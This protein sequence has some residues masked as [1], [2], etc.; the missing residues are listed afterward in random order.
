M[1]DSD[2]KSKLITLPKEKL[3]D[4]LV[5]IYQAGVDS[6]CVQIDLLADSSNIDNLIK[7]IEATLAQWK[8]RRAFI[9]YSQSFHYAR[10]IMVV[11]QKIEHE[12]IPVDPAKALKLIKK[13]LKSEAKLIEQTDDSGG[14]IGHE[15]AKFPLL[16]LKAASMVKKRS[17]KILDEVLAIAMDNDYGI[18]DGFLE[19]ADILLGPDDLRRLLQ[20]VITMAGT[21]RI[22]ADEFDWT[23]SRLT[24][25]WGEVACALKDPEEY[26]H[27]VR[28]YSQHPNELQRISIAKI[29]LRFNDAKGAIRILDKKDWQGYSGENRLALLE[30]C[31]ELL[32]DLEKV[33][34]I[35]RERY[36]SFPGEF[37]YKR[38]CE[39]LSGDEKK[40]LHREAIEKALSIGDIS[41]AVNFLLA[42]DEADRAE[43]LII[44]RQEMISGAF[45]DSLLTLIDKFLPLHKIVACVVLYR[46]LLLAILEKGYT[47][48]YNHGARYYKKLAEFDATLSE[49]PAGV[50]THNEFIEDLKSAHGR[51]RSFWSK[52]G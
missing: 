19:H 39:F 40:A 1:D 24:T 52:V 23:G 45:Y 50:I 14:D 43:A 29:Y 33:K 2:I 31:Y 8:R 30:E 17:K 12:I 13:F 11:R 3:V 51:K 16:W 44:E 46:T 5:S 15:L 41:T 9:S 48:A 49:Y 32:N 26:E 34:E 20:R 38:Y 28:F 47:K 27:S 37:N 7:T 42:L 18:R 6:I 36:E 10:E 25:L 35:C 4:T 22:N 21:R